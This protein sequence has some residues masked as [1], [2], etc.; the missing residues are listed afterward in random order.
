M[1]NY[2]TEKTTQGP[3][4]NLLFLGNWIPILSC[5][6]SFPVNVNAYIPSPMVVTISPKTC[7]V[8][9]GLLGSECKLTMS[10]IFSVMKCVPIWRCHLKSTKKI[11]RTNTN[12][13]SRKKTIISFSGK[14]CQL[15]K[16]GR[17]LTTRSTKRKGKREHVLACQ[18][19]LKFFHR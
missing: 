11:K 19:N 8:V 10:H 5:N 18:S 1:L 16:R 7:Q 6:T 3:Y 14:S 13:C 4:L 17:T 2:K 15:D 9:P 12:R